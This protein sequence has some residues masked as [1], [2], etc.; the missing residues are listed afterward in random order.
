LGVVFLAWSAVLCAGSCA[1]KGFPPGGPP[2]VTPPNVL[3]V[4]PDS[5]AARVAVNAPIS[6]TFDDKMDRES[7]E[8]AFN[9]TPPTDME[10]LKWTA[11]C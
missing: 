8:S 9:I 1:Q 3:F 11:R 2:D 4:Y 5:G 7:V 10:S 6:I